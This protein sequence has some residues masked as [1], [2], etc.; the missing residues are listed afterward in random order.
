MAP[1]IEQGDEPFQNAPATPDATK[2]RDRALPAIHAGS[3]ALAARALYQ[4]SPLP[5]PPCRLQALYIGDALRSDLMWTHSLRSFPFMS[6]KRLHSVAE[7]LWVAQF[8]LKLMGASLGRQMAVVR[9]PDD[10]G[11]V[12]FSPGPPD[13]EVQHDLAR[14]GPVR[15][16]VAPSCF[17]DTFVS[18]NL[19]AYPGATFHAAPGFE[20]VFKADRPVRH[21][22]GALPDSWLGV[23]ETQLIDGMPKVN[24]VVFHHLSSRTLIVADFVFNISSGVDLWTQAVLR[25]VGAY[26][27][28]RVSRIFRAMIR[29][30]IAQRASVSQVLAW[31]FDRL[32]PSHGKVIISGARA[33]VARA[34]QA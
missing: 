5:L 1:L 3:R 32:V 11:L 14:L 9:L 15:H 24:E 31:N 10:G 17:H 34:W 30:R 2:L 26:G 18:E 4:R 6:L 13:D 25:M 12:L 19:H 27:G 20:R 29:D 22:G 8:P 21:L 23:F 33:E 16:L 7:D 28:V